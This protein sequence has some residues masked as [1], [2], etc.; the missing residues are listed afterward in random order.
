VVAARR[1]AILVMAGC[2]SIRMPMPPALMARS[3]ATA[4]LTPLPRPTAS[5]KGDAMVGSVGRG[6]SAAVVGEAPPA[7]KA[8]ANTEGELLMCTGEVVPVAPGGADG[9][10]GPWAIVVAAE[11]AAG[12]VWLG[13]PVG[14]GAVDALGATA[15]DDVVVDLVSEVDVSPPL[16]LSVED[17]LPM[18]GEVDPWRDDD[19]DPDSVSG[20]R[21]LASLPEVGTMLSDLGAAAVVPE[22]YFWC[23]CS[24]PERSRRRPPPSR[25]TPLSSLSVPPWASRRARFAGGGGGAGSA[26]DAV[27]PAGASLA[28]RGRLAT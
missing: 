11:A 2:S 23:C 6:S 27:D 22:G 10:A 26:L 3:P 4:A 13:G 8:A 25:C 1:L 12:D 9:A 20:E 18:V 21:S 17:R 16:L 7:A 19:A 5:I 15:D 28:P 14:A 24:M